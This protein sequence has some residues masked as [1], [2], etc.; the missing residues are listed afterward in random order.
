VN[1]V[2]FGD[3]VA[4]VHAHAED[5]TPIFRQLGIVFGQPVLR[6]DRTLHRADR[7]GELHQQAVPRRPDNAPTIPGDL[8]LD[9][10]CAQFP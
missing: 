6:L 5:H 3:D 10:F 4:Q 1:R 7:A 9:H 8:R 2:T